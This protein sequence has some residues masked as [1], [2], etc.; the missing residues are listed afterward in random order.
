MMRDFAEA[1]MLVT[2]AT[3]GL[4]KR[5]ALKLAG[6]G[7]AVLLHGKNF[8]AATWYDTIAAL[9]GAGYHIAFSYHGGVNL[10]RGTHRYDVKRVSVE[11][12]LSR[13]LFR[14]A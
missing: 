2:G 10:P 3:D 8:C 6:T 1:T 13:P 11:A 14:A 5:V 7:A 12:D 9:A 4:G